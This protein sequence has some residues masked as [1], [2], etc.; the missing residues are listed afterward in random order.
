LDVFEILSPLFQLTF[1]SEIPIDN[2]LATILALFSALAR[3]GIIPVWLLMGGLNYRYSLGY[4]VDVS[5]AA[6]SLS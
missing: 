6:S 2:Q 1:S 3:A 5:H 4:L